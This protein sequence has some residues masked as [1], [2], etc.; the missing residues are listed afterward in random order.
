MMPDPDR[1]ET[2]GVHDVVVLHA[3]GVRAE[4]VP[5]CG[6]R[7][8]ALAIDGFDVI[9]TGS[10]ADDPMAWGCYPMVPWAGRVRRG[11]F[12]F[13]GLDH[14][15]EVNLPPHAIHGT[16]FRRAWDV[17]AATSQQVEMTTELGTGWPLG[18]RATS[19]IELTPGGLRWALAVAAGVGAMPAQVGWHPWFV[20][21]VSAELRF[22]RMLV[23]DPDGIPTGDTVTPPP[24]PWDDCFEEPLAPLR[25]GYRAPTTP[26]ELEVSSDCACWV[27]FD[28]PAHATCVE[29][30]SG[31]PD[32]LTTRP[33]VLGPG[34]RLERWMQIAWNRAPGPRLPSRSSPPVG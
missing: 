22:A 5:A 9:V 12:H 30:Q 11:R 7:L 3:D 25:L 15:L 29:P 17:V 34:D 13:A 14:Q 33:D 24:G 26:L 31:P 32:G 19:R 1:C 8:G 4:V 6:G 2:H 18:G 20:K 27:V 16:G 28:E 23:R 21:P 10:S